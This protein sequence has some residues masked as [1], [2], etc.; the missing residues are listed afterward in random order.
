MLTLGLL[1]SL[2]KPRVVEVLRLCKLFTMDFS[3]F[4]SFNCSPKSSS[5]QWNHFLLFKSGLRQTHCRV[6]I[7]YLSDFDFV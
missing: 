6:N 3:R 7:I 1:T 4:S 5:M 2:G